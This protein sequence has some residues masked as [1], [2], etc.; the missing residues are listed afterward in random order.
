MKSKHFPKIEDQ[1]R[2]RPRGILLEREW[3]AGGVLL[4]WAPTVVHT[5]KNTQS[6]GNDRVYCSVLGCLLQRD[7]ATLFIGAMGYSWQSYLW[8]FSFHWNIYSSVFSVTF[9][10]W[11]DNVQ[12]TPFCAHQGKV[13]E[14]PHFSISALLKK[15]RLGNILCFCPGKL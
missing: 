5:D 12:M 4:T 10:F 11:R 1:R 13:R 14:C 15:K 3:F 7:R 9:P 2:P 6:Q 8:N